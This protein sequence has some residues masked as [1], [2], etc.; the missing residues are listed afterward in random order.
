MCTSLPQMPQA[1]TSIRTWPGP[2]F[3]TATSSIASRGLCQTR[4]PR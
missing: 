2:G 1:F 3:G 4:L